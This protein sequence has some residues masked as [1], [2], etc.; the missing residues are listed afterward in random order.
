[1]ICLFPGHE[2]ADLKQNQWDSGY[3]EDELEPLADS[4]STRCE[5][6]N[7]TCVSGQCTHE[8]R[9]KSAFEISHYYIIL[10]NITFS[11]Q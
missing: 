11:D 1:M 3:E 10:L 6:L 4:S 7:F 8:Y 5:C 9:G 2:S